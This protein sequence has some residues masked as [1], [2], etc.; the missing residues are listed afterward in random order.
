MSLGSKLKKNQIYYWPF[1]SG[2]LCSKRKNHDERAWVITLLPIYNNE[3]DNNVGRSTELF[4]RLRRGDGGG[5]RAKRNDDVD[6][7]SV[8]P[9]PYN[10]DIIRHHDETMLCA[11]PL[12]SCNPKDNRLGRSDIRLCFPLINPRRRRLVLYVR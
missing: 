11:G 8:I 12:S 10:I 4:P 6:R 2:M 1:L 7:A 3:H 5:Q 9:Y